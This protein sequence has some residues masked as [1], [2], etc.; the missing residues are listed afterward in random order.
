MIR[1]NFILATATAM[2]ACT[3]ALATRKV[4][5][6]KSADFEI[7]A[8]PY[9]CGGGTDSVN[10]VFAVNKISLADVYV[11]SED[12]IDFKEPVLY[13]ESEQTGR[14]HIG[15][16][17]N[18]KIDGLK[19]GKTYFYK[20][21]AKELVKHWEYRNKKEKIYRYG[22]TILGKIITLEK[23]SD[24]NPLKFTL[25][26]A[27]GKKLTFAVMND[28]HENPEKIDKLFKALPND[29]YDFLV[30]NGD[31]VNLMMEEERLFKRTVGVV[32]KNL[33]SVKP[34]YFLRGN[35]E[36]RG[37]SSEDYFRYFPSPSGKTYYAFK[38]GPVFFLFLD[39]CEDKPDSSKAG[40]HLNDYSKYR[41]KEVAWLKEVVK[42]SD[43]KNA[44]Y[45]IAIQHI[46]PVG[47]YLAYRGKNDLHISEVLKDVN[48]D[49]MLCGHI[50]RHCIFSKGNDARD[51]YNT[52]EKA[53]NVM[54][55]LVK[56]EEAKVHYPIIANSHRESMLVHV[57]EEN[58]KI[59]FLDMNGTK[60]NADYIYTP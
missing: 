60:T 57:S 16:I 22:E 41:N 51:L 40:E 29:D 6:D 33:K 9:L 30:L 21:V 15:T 38:A 17:H 56:A 45:R 28:L 34:V 23:N 20:I 58:I 32:S 4:V 5:A 36:T 59:E 35:H 25:P 12:D 14:K 52:S 3:K 53:R 7:I 24:N 50:H 27:N 48:V 37:K 26:K 49:I 39:L 11:W 18:I 8:T 54:K 46:P 13:V 42:Q 31:F 55:K 19:D 10:V 43:F 44:K 1:R 47:E 2:L